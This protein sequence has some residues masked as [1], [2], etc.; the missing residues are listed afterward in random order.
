MD[1]FTGA[2]KILS[3]VPDN[4]ALLD[5]ARKV[6]VLYGVL[7]AGQKLGPLPDPL[8]DDELLPDAENGKRARVSGP[9]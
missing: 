8:G 5:E 6:L 7:P 4:G 9:S 1:D 2:L 3:L